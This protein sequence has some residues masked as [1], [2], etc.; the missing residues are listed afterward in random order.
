MFRSFLGVILLSF[1]ACLC[2]AVAAASPVELIVKRDGGLTKSERLDIRSSAGVSLERPM[3]IKNFE[4][5]TV[6]SSKVKEALADLNSNSD[7]VFAEQNTRAFATAAPY[8]IPVNDPLLSL[9]YSIENTGQTINNNSNTI[10]GSDMK[11]R[12]AWNLARGAGVVVAVA[13]TGIELSH[14]DLSSRVA[15]NSSEIA[16]DG[17]DNDNNGYIDDTNGWDF[18]DGDKTPAAS[19]NGHGTHV[20]GIIA[21]E[22]NNSQGISG[23]APAARTLPLRVLGADG[24]GTWSQIAEAFDYAGK[25]N[26]PIVNASLGGYGSV[27]TIDSV[28]ASHPNT[29]YVFA[30]GND[31][32]SLDNYTFYPCESPESNVLCVGATDPANNVASFSNYSPTAVDI[33]APGEDIAST[34][35]GAGYVWLSGTSMAAPNVSAVAALVAGASFRRGAVLKDTLTTTADMSLGGWVASGHMNAFSAVSAVVIDTDNDGLSDSVDQCPSVFSTR[36]D[37]CLDSD[38]DNISDNIDNCPDVSNSNQLDTDSDGQGDA[39]DST[40]NGPD[41]DG[42]GILDASDNCPNVSN[43]NQLDTDS[44]GQGDACDSTPN[45][46]DADSDGILDTSD[47]CPNVSNANQLDTDNDGQGDV[48]DP[49]PNG[50]DVP[51]ADTDNDGVPD[52]S[53]NCPDVSNANQL[54]TDSDGQGDVCD[55][56]PNGPD[57]D[58]DGIIDASDNCPN[59]SNAN[60]LDT[61]NDGQGDVC[62]PTPNGVDVPPADTDNDGVPD[63]SD[64]CPNV[65]NANQLDTDNDGQGD[66]CD[67]T[68]NGVDVP[69]AD[70]DGD[71]IANTSDN[72]PAVSNAN[73]LDTDNDGQGDVCDLTPNGVIIPPADA[74]SDGLPDTS[75]NCPAVSNANQL[76]TDSDGQGD[77]CDPCPDEKGSNCQ[78]KPK[79]TL[80]LKITQKV[81]RATT[82]VTTKSQLRFTLKMKSCSS[83]R[84]RTIK[85]SSFDSV[86]GKKTTL[87]AIKKKGFYLLTAR[88]SNNK[89]SGLSSSSAHKR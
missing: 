76:D 22:Q 16:G 48:C 85:T 63:T 83:C 54:D 3:T 6:D 72:C 1:L 75:D 4:L 50:V 14:P 43:A 21:A 23:V 64:N 37:G 57:A 86:V 47:N 61:D 60:Q 39:C 38:G 24:S 15:S 58:S 41:A 28:I 80:S 5:V 89:G 51:P 31:G 77:V 73:Q 71:G 45:G 69:P 67:P 62:D 9:Q 59:V 65:S 32:V 18:V 25:M 82:F 26:I 46:P 19:D 7:V 29:L 49:T 36:S 13:D 33:A 35:T 42:D 81:L 70:N 10:A 44:D 11:V 17:I 68:P 79:V 30:A 52:T 12:P 20:A 74:D 84:Y 53:D 8:R 56:T 87:W 27:A 88:A 66:V 34:Y 55:S 40:P 78:T 2:P